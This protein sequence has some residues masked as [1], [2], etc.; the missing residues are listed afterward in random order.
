[1]DTEESTLWWKNLGDNFIKMEKFEE[2]IQCYEKATSLNPEYIPAWNNMGYSLSK[3]GRKEEAKTVKIKINDLKNKENFL[4]RSSEQ[5]TGINPKMA[6][7]A[8]IAAIL[9]AQLVGSFLFIYYGGGFQFLIN[10]LS[11]FNIGF[12]TLLFAVILLG[13]FFFIVLLKPFI[14]T[15]K[16]GVII[17]GIIGIIIISLIVGLLIFSPVSSVLTSMES[18]VVSET[19]PPNISVAVQIEKDPI[20]NTI[21]ALFVG[22]NGQSVTKYCIVR[23]TRSDGSVISGQLQPEKLAEVRIPGSSD[24]DRVEVFVVYYS[25]K[26]Y[27]IYDN[28]LTD[29]NSSSP[30]F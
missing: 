4:K 29:G 18:N 21:L 12:Y 7:K 28:Y 25:G 9:G 30:F 14:N 22:G 2:A 15:K 3:L 27:K 26:V 11:S 1:M 23:V 19:P 8:L 20:Y 24:S 10:E 5:K 16:I 13:I 17:I 6:I